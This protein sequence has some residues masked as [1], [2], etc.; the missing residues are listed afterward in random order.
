MAELSALRVVEAD[1]RAEVCCDCVCV[2]VLC[3][4]ILVRYGPWTGRSG[5]MVT[6]SLALLRSLPLWVCDWERVNL[7]VCAYLCVCVC[8]CVCVCQSAMTHWLSSAPCVW[9]RHT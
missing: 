5:V 1:L 8:V 6:A 4:G 7:H 3:V 2:C 9:S